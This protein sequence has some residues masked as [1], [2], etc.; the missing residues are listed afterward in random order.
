MAENRTTQVV[1]EVVAGGDP[2]A[3][4]TAVAAE[5]AGHTTRQAR[6]TQTIAEAL[7]GGS[8]LASVTAVAVEVLMMVGAPPPP[9]PGVTRRLAFITWDV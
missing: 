5:A 3:S 2:D 9:P 6:V 4:V 1:A 7:A 8:P